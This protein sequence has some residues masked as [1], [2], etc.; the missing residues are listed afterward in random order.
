MNFFLNLKPVLDNVSYILLCP[1]EGIKHISNL[2]VETLRSSENKQNQVR[3]MLPYFQ[4]MSASMFN[5][6]LCE[7]EAN[8]FLLLYKILD[9][10]FIMNYL[11]TIL[12]LL[13]V[14]MRERPCYS[15]MFIDVSC[16][17]RFLIRQNWS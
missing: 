10:F 14:I 15:Q 16:D 11:Y 5:I 1:L 4:K 2:A 9:I 7:S 6:I 17:V 3:L 8:N 13:N 12:T